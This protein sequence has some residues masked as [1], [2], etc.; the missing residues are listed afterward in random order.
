[1]IE[2]DVPIVKCI[3][4]TETSLMGVDISFALNP[5]VLNAYL[6]E[7][8]DNLIG[9]SHL[10][11]RSLI[12]CQNYFSNETHTL[13]SHNFMLGSHGLRIMVSFVLF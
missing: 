12:L 5:G 7:L 8:I 9:R 2:A 13:G 1:M 4:N 11:K 10:F 6:L 3:V